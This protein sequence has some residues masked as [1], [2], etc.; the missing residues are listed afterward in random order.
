MATQTKN[1]PPNSMERR[2]KTRKADKCQL[3]GTKTD[4]KDQYTVVNDLEAGKPIKKKNAA[5]RGAENLSHYC[6][7]CADKRVKQKQA[8]LD[9]RNGDAPKAKPAAKKA[10]KPKAAKAKTARKGA[11]TAAKKKA[12]VKKPKRV[13]KKKAAA[14]SA[15]PF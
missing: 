9:S 7:D 6:G 8:W 2:Q 11:P 14:D 15:D 10:A 12:A 4:L 1:Y 3:C 13:V 5:R